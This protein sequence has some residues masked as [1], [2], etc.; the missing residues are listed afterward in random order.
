M[1][2]PLSGEPK[3]PAQK[4]PLK[5]EVAA[6]SAD[7]GVANSPHRAPQKPPL[8]GEVAARSADGEVKG[9]GSDRGEVHERESLHWLQ[10]DVKAA[11]PGTAEKYDPPGEAPV[12]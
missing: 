3:R 12:V 4:P 11:E 7:G 1:T 2:A 5:G 10:R 9:K 8:K 6:R